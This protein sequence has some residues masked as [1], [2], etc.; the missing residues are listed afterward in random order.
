M[1][2]Q[3]HNELFTPGI[4]PAIVSFTGMIVRTET[5]IG[6]FGLEQPYNFTIIPTGWSRQSTI[7]LGF[8]DDGE[9]E[10]DDATVQNML[11]RTFHLTGKFLIGVHNLNR[12]IVP[13]HDSELTE[14]E[15]GI[16]WRITGFI[17]RI[18]SFEYLSTM[19]RELSVRVGG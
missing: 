12:G 4:D 3:D 10:L 14:A 19:Y 11:Y 1:T 6:D 16:C 7:R 13:E 17:R 15:I 18:R 9:K 5:E 2:M 8:R